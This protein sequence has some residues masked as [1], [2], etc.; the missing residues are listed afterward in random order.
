MCIRDRFL[1]FVSRIL[2]KMMRFMHL[3]LFAAREFLKLWICH[4]FIIKSREVDS[5]EWNTTFEFY[6][7]CMGGPL[8]QNY[9]E[10]IPKPKTLSVESMQRKAVDLPKIAYWSLILGNIFAV[11]LCLEKKIRDILAVTRA[12]ITW[13]SYFLAKALL[14]DWAI[15]SW[16]I[17][18]LTWI[19]FKHYMYLVKHKRRK[20]RLFN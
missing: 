2:H 19:V 17:S 11:T 3:C 6:K 14:R 15:K 13:L 12:S 20:M 18:H 16:F 1:R 7:V 5:R 8:S 9:L 4:E 10:P